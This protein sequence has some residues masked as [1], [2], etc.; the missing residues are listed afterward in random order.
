MECVCVMNLITITS[1]LT[2]M[3]STYCSVCLSAVLLWPLH[4][5]SFTH[6]LYSRVFYTLSFFLYKAAGFAGKHDVAAHAELQRLK[7][8]ANMRQAWKWF[9]GSCFAAVFDP[10]LTTI[11]Y[12]HCTWFGSMQQI[13]SDL[14]CFVCCLRVCTSK[15]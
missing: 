13:C 8:S 10:V 12:L 15:D 11:A 14:V 2:L 4:T 1:T 6:L 7:V 5:V 9:P 3:S